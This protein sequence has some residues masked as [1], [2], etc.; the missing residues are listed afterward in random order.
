MHAFTEEY[1][2][3]RI[4]TYKP[5]D[6]PDRGRL[7]RS[8]R[9]QKPADL[10]AMKVEGGI[11]DGR[12]IPES[13]GEALDLEDWI[14]GHVVVR[15]ELDVVSEKGVDFLESQARLATRDQSFVDGSAQRPRRGPAGG[16][17]QL[18]A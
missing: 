3:P 13:L 10:A 7:A 5:E 14:D 8:V 15:F 12:H 17:P 11:R 9:A 4:G 1:R 16:E 2:L 18:G 6:H